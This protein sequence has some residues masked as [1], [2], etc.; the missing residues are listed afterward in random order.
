MYLKIW[1][2]HPGDSQ[3]PW[4]MFQAPAPRPVPPRRHPKTRPRPPRRRG[5]LSGDPRFSVRFFGWNLQKLMKLKLMKLKSCPSN[6]KSHSKK[7]HRAVSSPGSSRIGSTWPSSL[8]PFCPS[9]GG[10]QGAGQSSFFSQARRKHPLSGLRY[11]TLGTSHQEHGCL[12]FFWWEIL[13]NSTA[14]QQPRPACMGLMAWWA[15]HFSQNPQVG[16]IWKE[17]SQN[18]KRKK[19]SNEM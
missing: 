13:W 4:L 2:I 8:V 1:S 5:G 12:V 16:A 15:S 3:R 10:Q 19:D 6:T 7:S 17:V 18:Q 11:G 9:P 14:S